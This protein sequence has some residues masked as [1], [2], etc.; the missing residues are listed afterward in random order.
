MSGNISGRTLSGQPIPDPNDRPVTCFGGHMAGP[1]LPR[2]KQDMPRSIAS[3][4]NVGPGLQGST[5][6]SNWR[7]QRN[8]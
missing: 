6:A 7:R 1:G 8:G 3:V 2:Q 4:N 5:N